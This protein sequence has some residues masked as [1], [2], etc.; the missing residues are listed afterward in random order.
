MLRIVVRSGFTLDMA[1]MLLED[2]RK[3][4]ARLEKLPSPVVQADQ[5]SSFHH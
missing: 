5:A 4:L 1:D 3:Q 2:L